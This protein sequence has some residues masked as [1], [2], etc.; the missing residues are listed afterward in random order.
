MKTIAHPNKPRTVFCRL[1]HLMRWTGW[2]ERVINDFVKEG[3]LRVRDRPGCRRLFFVPSA[4]EIIDQDSIGKNLNAVA[5]GRLGG[6]KVGKARAAALSARERKRIATKAA[7][8]RWTRSK[9]KRGCS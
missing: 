1:R 9:S 6:L 3:L 7:E 5:L 8:A 2:S 4:Q